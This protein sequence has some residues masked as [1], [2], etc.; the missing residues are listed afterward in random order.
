M[1]ASTSKRGMEFSKKIIIAAGLLFVV[2]LFDIRSAVRAGIDVSG[3]ATQQILTTGGILGAAIIFYLNKSKIENLAKGKIRFTLL[4]LR[5]ELKLKDRIPEESYQLVLNE[6]NKIDGM[7]D[8]KLDG[9]L[10]AAI[11][12]EVDIQHY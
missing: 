3:Y 6:I 1:S 8:S 9:A 2:S 11:Q 4:K 12:Q 5:L 10:E 7:L